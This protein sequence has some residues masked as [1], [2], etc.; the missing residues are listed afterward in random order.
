MK[1]KNKNTFNI[2]VVIPA[3]GGSV[4]V[5]RKN[6][7]SL[8]GEPLIS[9]VIKAAL[10][11]KYDLDVIVSTDNHE[12]ADI[13]TKYGAKAPFLR[14]KE[15]SGSNSTLIL[16]SKHALEYFS[17]KGTH[18][19]AVLSL[20]PTAPLITSKTIDK[21]IDKL[22]DSDFTSIITVSEMVQGHP[23]TAKRLLDDGGL[24][25]FVD[26]PEGAITFPRQKREKPFYT[27]GAIYLRLSSLVETYE[28]GGWQLGDK[29]GYIIMDE[30]ESI[31]IN[32][33]MDF[34]WAE[35]ILQDKHKSRF[36]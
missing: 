29:P 19:D 12:I 25:S 3:R 34:A 9:Y 28:D 27:N 30:K 24:E 18:Y 13:A 36:F 8:N 17:S 6:I 1:E 11:S 16:T 23:Y 35:F 32:N 7:K 33:V 26:I 15:I 5:P 10:N 2:L 31:D 14:P 20:Q 22:T 21:T 4:G